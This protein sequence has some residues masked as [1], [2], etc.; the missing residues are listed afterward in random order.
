MGWANGPG[1][2]GWSLSGRSSGVEHNLAKVGVG[3][4]NRLARS[5]FQKTQTEAISEGSARA[6]RRPDVD[7]QQPAVAI[8]H[9]NGLDPVEG[10]VGPGKGEQAVGNVI[11][12][13]MACEVFEA[14][15]ARFFDF[16]A[17][18]FG[19]V[20]VGAIGPVLTTG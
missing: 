14:I 5:I 11:H 19:L 15:V 16:H 10:P 3:R 2:W 9:G 7:D 12:P 8:G 17:R 18:V 20:K 4:S 13:A 6:G 1:Y